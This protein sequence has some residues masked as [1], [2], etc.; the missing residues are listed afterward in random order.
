ML[1]RLP[2]GHER[3]REHH[4]DVGASF[5]DDGDHNLVLACTSLTAFKE[6]DTNRSLYAL[7]KRANVP[8]DAHHMLRHI[9]SGDCNDKGRH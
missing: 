4:G 8:R 3:H 5:D 9:Y 1:R 6:R 7:Q 2:A